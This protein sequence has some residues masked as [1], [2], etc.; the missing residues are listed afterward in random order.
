MPPVS[1]PYFINMKRF[2][3]LAVLSIVLGAFSAGFAQVGLPIEGRLRGPAP[4]IDVIDGETLLVRI[5]DRERDVLLNGIDAPE[6]AAGYLERLVSGGSVFLEFDVANPLLYE[7]L[8]FAYVYVPDPRG[9]WEKDGQRYTQVN[10]ELLKVGLADVL[11]IPPDIPY[12]DLFVATLQD[13]RD[14]ERGIWRDGDRQPRGAQLSQNAFYRRFMPDGE[15]PPLIDT[16]GDS[17]AAA[18]DGNTAT[19]EFDVQQFAA[20]RGLD[21]TRTLPSLNQNRTN[22]QDIVDRL[23]IAQADFGRT[24]VVPTSSMTGTSSINADGTMDLARAGARPAAPSTAVGQTLNNVQAL[25]SQMNTNSTGRGAVGLMGTAENP[26]PQ[27]TTTEERISLFSPTMSQSLAQRNM[28][29]STMGAPSLM[30]GASMIGTASITFS[31]EPGGAF[32]WIDGGLVGN[33]PISINLPVGQ[34][35]SYTV[36]DTQRR[37]NP[38]NGSVSVRGDE[39]LNVALATGIVTSNMAVPMPVSRQQP[40]VNPFAP[41][42]PLA[43]PV[44]S[45]PR[46]STPQ[47]STP[48]VIPTEAATFR[49][50]PLGP[51]RNCSDFTTQAEAQ[52]FFDAAGGTGNDIHQLDR[53]GDGVVCTGLP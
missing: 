21:T 47:T 5:N 11:A 36:S 41:V 30:A 31:S 17:V 34:L 6:D 22:Q 53:N 15:A 24:G 42:Q 46:A 14:N 16:F 20:E 27:A 25:L 45:A 28:A 37:F 43:A 4:V 23:R 18:E 7:P 32:V 51:D 40:S 8:P 12:V 1:V 2:V 52:A 50:D 29:G 9:D 26:F 13:A 19:G 3:L 48:R 38:V 33:T 44:Q 39:M 10:L 49:Y 35:Y